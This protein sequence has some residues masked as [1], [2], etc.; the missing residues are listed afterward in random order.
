[1]SEH[2]TNAEDALEQIC[3]RIFGPDLILRSPVVVESSG[4]KEVADVL[5]AIDDVLIIIQSK[6]VQIDATELDEIGLNRI[7]KRHE[8]AKQQLNTALN[9]EARNAQ[10]RG[11]TVSGVEYETDWARIKR[12]IGIVTLNVND[13]EFNDPDRRFQFPEL[14]A[15]QRGVEVHTFVLRDLWHAA[16]ELTTPGDVLLYLEAR[17]DCLSTG[18]IAALNELDFL[19][20]FKTDYPTLDAMIRGEVA[21]LIAPGVW[22][23]YRANRQSE[24]A[25]RNARFAT[26]VV[27]D[28]ILRRL[29]SAVEYSCTAHGVSA[30]E[31]ARNYMLT[32]GKLSKLTRVERAKIGRMLQEKA[33][34]TAHSKFGYFA[35]VSEQA[36]TCY[37]F[38]LLNDEDREERVELL[39]YLAE[40]ICHQV[41]TPQLVAMVTAGSKIEESSVDVAVIDVAFVKQ[42]T[43]LESEPMFKEMK[44]EVL[45]E[46]ADS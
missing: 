9:A 19:A 36:K 32:I 11:L 27:F 28:T 5:V 4:D 12:R 17:R 18:R 8:K 34:K 42:Q 25:D 20:Q 37:L 38:V 39:M 7:R 44:S 29:Q 13:G 40:Q 46:W 6:S 31:S 45:N 41:D 2:G 10:V 14:L 22:E 43:T 24:I 16:N 15:E 1:M 35:Y 21:C 33:K 23:S 3:M 30:R 26:S